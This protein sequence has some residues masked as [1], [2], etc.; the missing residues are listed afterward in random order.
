MKPP[1][2][3]FLTAD[4]IAGLQSLES[5]SVN[6]CVTSPPYW[7]LRDYGTGEWEGGS[8]ECDHE[9]VFPGICGKCGARRVDLQIGL[10]DTPEK[11]VEKLVTI[12]R[13]VWRVLKNEG[14]VWLN[15]GD[16]FYG[17]G[18][19]NNKSTGGATRI[20]GGKQKHLCS[21]AKSD[22]KSKDLIGIPWRVAFALQADGWYLRQD[23]IWAKPNPMP[24]S[25]KDR[26]TKSHEYVFLLSKQTKYYFDSKAIKEPLACPK[27]DGRKTPGKFG[28]AN[29][30]KEAQ[31]QSR[32]HS[33]HEYLGTKDNKRNKRSV[34]NIAPQPYKEAHFAVFPEALVE[35]M[36]LAGCPIGGT[37]LDPF[38]GS[39]T[40]ILTALKNGRRG[41]GIELKP[42]YTKLAEN[43]IQEWI[44]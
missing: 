41:L 42:E 40:T 34:W 28:G 24:E 13:E 39:G 10:E 12:F 7:G 38:A 2:Y 32:L 20:Q 36:I 30:F 23:I 5:E 22:L 29:K 35:P 37:V 14:T 11:Y 25:V 9:K 8:A 44:G 21:I 43:R 27:E 3:F 33:G 1:T 17:T 15:L 31:K 4:A 26:C 6:C 18:Y 16:S 19:S